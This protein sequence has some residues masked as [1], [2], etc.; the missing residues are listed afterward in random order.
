MKLSLPPANEFTPP[1]QMV[2]LIGWMLQ[3]FAMD[4]NNDKLARAYQAVLDIFNE[5]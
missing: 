2:N 5:E 3:G 4:P 1:Q